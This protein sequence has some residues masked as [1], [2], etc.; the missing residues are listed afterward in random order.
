MEI[1]KRKQRLS[2]EYAGVKGRIMILLSS[3]TL[4]FCGCS[5]ERADACPSYFMPIVQ[6]LEASRH[7]NIGIGRRQAR[8][9][10]RTGHMFV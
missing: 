4:L 6:E 7:P 5:A 2:W 9:R 10:E 8:F 1:N 3:L